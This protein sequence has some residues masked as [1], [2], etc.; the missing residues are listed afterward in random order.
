VSLIL[1]SIQKEEETPRQWKESIILPVYKKCDKL[2][3]INYQ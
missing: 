3:C 2:G 1:N